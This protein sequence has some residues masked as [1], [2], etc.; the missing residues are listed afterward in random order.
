MRNKIRLYDP[1]KERMREAASFQSYSPNPCED[2]L[3]LP[4]AS[5]KN[6]PLR[7]FTIALSNFKLDLACGSVSLS[8]KKKNGFN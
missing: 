3:P 7:D 6:I 5:P 8:Q 4:C 1:R 2:Q